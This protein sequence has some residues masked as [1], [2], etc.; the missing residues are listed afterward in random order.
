MTDVKRALKDLGLALLNATLMLAVILFVLVLL[1]LNK[2]ADITSRVKQ[3]SMVPAEIAAAL[4]NDPLLDELDRLTNNLASVNASLETVG[5]GEI[6]EEISAELSGQIA[7]LKQQLS[8]LS[9]TL[10]D[11]ASQCVLDIEQVMNSS[12]EALLRGGVSSAINTLTP[13]QGQADRNRE[14]ERLPTFRD[15]A[16]RKERN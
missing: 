14:V 7:L 15:K 3:V 9:Q 6:A 1:V 13:G 5:G 10:E 11:G 4:E 2:A 8:S 12:L 16:L